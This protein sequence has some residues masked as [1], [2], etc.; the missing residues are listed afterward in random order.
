MVL[1]LFGLIFSAHAFSLP[2]C[3]HESGGSEEDG[4]M[5]INYEKFGP[6]Q[7][8][9]DSDALTLGLAALLPILRPFPKSESPSGNLG[10]QLV[11]SD[12][13]EQGFDLY[14]GTGFP[15]TAFEYAKMVEP[16]LGVPP[17]IDLGEA[18][19]IPLYVDGVQT[20]GNLGRFCDNPTYLGKETI[21]G[22]TLQRYQGR[23]AGGEPLSEVIWISFGRN[24]SPNHEYVIGSVQMIG[25]NKKTGATAFFESSDNL[26]PW[27]TLDE[28]T[29]RMRGVMPWID[30]PE[31]FNRA[32]VTPG[33][34]QCVECHQADP[35]ITDAF[36]NAAKIPGTDQ[37]VVPILNENS[38]YYVIGG[39]NWDMRTI[40][41]E[42]NGCFECH[43]VGMS[44][45]ELFV[46]NG[47]DP[48][49]HMPP[50]DPGSLAEDFQELLNAWESGPQN[51]PGAEWMIPPARGQDRQVVGD[52]YPFKASFNGPGGSDRKILKKPSGSKFLPTT[53]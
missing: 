14:P 29:L 27:V 53:D 22:S 8:D 32:F 21:S 20:Y 7:R 19:E 31:E 26:A 2:L 9:L 51:V 48:N 25:Y 16:E 23:R 47:W 3:I 10:S 43:R 50:Y 41:I 36:I 45:L 1:F 46:R 4:P 37:N 42:G 17:R 35:F 15:K 13:A 38:P 40:Y 39:E 44:T 33:R 52:D 30:D 11:A 49:Q 34:V 24:S 18:V 28:E 12:S 6:P 5:L